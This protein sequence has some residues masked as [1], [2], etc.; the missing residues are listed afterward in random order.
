MD[1]SVLSGLPDG[2]QV[3]VEMGNCH[4]GGFLVTVRE[5]RGH[6]AVRGSN[7]GL[8]ELYAEIGG[9]VV[10]DRM[11]PECR[12]G[13]CRRRRKAERRARRAERRFEAE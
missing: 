11:P 1:L 3:R 2:H 9:Y 5:L 8:A 7:P 6:E 4:N 12:C 10:V 13:L